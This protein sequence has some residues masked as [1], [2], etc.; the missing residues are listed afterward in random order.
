[1]IVTDDNPK[2]KTW[3]NSVRF[4]AQCAYDG[5]PLTGA[6]WLKLTFYLR[7]PKGHYGTGRNER[8]LK[9]SA[10]THHTQTPDRTK[11]IR[12]TEDALKGILWQDDAQV[13]DGPT[14]KQWCHRWQKEGVQIVV[15]AV[16]DTEA[17]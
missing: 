3:R 11:L 13:M 12:S 6:V 4:A 8:L 14:R 16:A 10:P 2:V 9:P 7:R 1:M 5:E 15:E 17:Y